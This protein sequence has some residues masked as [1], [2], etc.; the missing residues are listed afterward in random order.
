MTVWNICFTYACDQ[1]TPM[2]GVQLAAAYVV[3][4]YFAECSKHKT[5]A[6]VGNGFQPEQCLH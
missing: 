4:P 6:N 3:K 1:L 2:C 5:K